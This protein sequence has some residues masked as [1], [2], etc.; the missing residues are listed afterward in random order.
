MAETGDGTNGTEG[1]GAYIL[2]TEDAGNTWKVE[3]VNTDTDASIIGIAA[4]GEKEFWAV[5]G[6]L[7]V[8]T[9]QYSQFYHSLDAGSSWTRLDDP[10]G[11]FTF[12]YAIDLDCEMGENCWVA[13]LDVLTQ[14][15]SIGRLK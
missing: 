7:G 3:H 6:H 5:G 11:N 1:G 14:E 8:I 4:I 13:T 10:N 12:Q 15:S 2:C 9:V